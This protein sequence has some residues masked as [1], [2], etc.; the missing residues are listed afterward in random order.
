MATDDAIRDKVEK[1]ILSLAGGVQV[2]TLYGEKH[3]LTNESIDELFLIIDDVLS[4]VEEITVGIIGNEIAFEK[5]PFYEIAVRIEGFIGHLKDIGFE[6]V[7][8]SRGVSREDLI[9]LIKIISM[10]KEQASARGGVKRMLKETGIVTITIGEIGYLKNDDQ[11]GKQNEA[12]ART[13]EKF[14]EGV[15][16]IKSTYEN[17]KGK[18][19]INT[20]SARQLVSGMINELLKNKNLL[21]M[22]TSTKSHD[23]FMFV[24][25]VNVAVF[26]LVQAE[27]LGIEQKYLQEI[28][29][30]ALLNDIGKLSNYECDD[31]NGKEMTEEDKQAVGRE[32]LQGAKILLETEGIGVLSAIASFE[33]DMG[34]DMSGYPKKLYGKGLNFI[35]MIIAI[36]DYYDKLRNSPSYYKEGGPEKVYEIMMK[37]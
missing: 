32:N 18:K 22:L 28:G 15:E 8:F 33:R 35:T 3:R 17:L 1:L 30:A 21:L 34:Y 6:K 31:K 13:K 2:M 36:A 23:E 7:S 11:Q 29:V 37:L 19:P 9:E 24:H 10:K 25:G 4:A 20:Q 12:D 27:A 5:K 16:Y 14:Q 26:S